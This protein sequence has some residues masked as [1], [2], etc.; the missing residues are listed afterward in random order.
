M[1]KSS[2]QRIRGGLVV[3]CQARGDNP[4]SGADY[5]LAMAKAAQLGGAVGI[6]AEGEE[7]IRTI[8]QHVSLPVI[9]LIKEVYPDSPVYI[10][11]TKKEV[12]QVIAASA[13]IIAIDATCQ[14]R[15][16]QGSPD[17]VRELVK[18]VHQAGK[19]A[20][21]DISTF[22]EAI[23]AESLGFDVIGTTLSGYTSYSPKISGPDLDLV[24]SIAKRCKVPVIAEGRYW[25][26]E[27]VGKALELGAWAVV[28]G[29]AITNPWLI[30]KRFVSYINTHSKKGSG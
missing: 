24:Q 16:G 17:S 1:I 29:S 22:D 28:V 21:A 15:P 2:L 3:S 14:E 25:T 6:R 27:D 30:T 26:P 20:M 23:Q 9:G 10:T 12:K 5:M 4:L 18:L 8:E 19:L 11:P 13:D 7:D